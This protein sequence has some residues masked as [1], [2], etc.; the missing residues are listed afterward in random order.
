MNSLPSQILKRCTQCSWISFS[1]V[2]PNLYNRKL[3]EVFLNTV[4]VLLILIGLFLLSFCYMISDPEIEGESART[5][6]SAYLI[7]LIPL[8]IGVLLLIRSYLRNK[9]LNWDT[10]HFYNQGNKIF[11]CVSSL[12]LVWFKSR[13]YGFSG[14]HIPCN[15]L[16]L[17]KMP[18]NT[19]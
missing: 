16:F 1:R 12:F 5:P 19:W 8:F 14:V 3:L 7:S 6:L 17:K 15:K 10:A 9:F 13:F 18:W 4:G 2:K 11:L